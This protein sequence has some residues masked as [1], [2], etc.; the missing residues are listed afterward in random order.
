MNSILNIR[1]T[2]E[3]RQGILTLDEGMD[4]IPELID[5]LSAGYTRKEAEKMNILVRIELMNS[6]LKKTDLKETDEE[7]INAF[8]KE[9]ETLIKEYNEL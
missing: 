3:Y 7:E 6:H 1:P 4:N 5:Y 8:K 2:K 9:I